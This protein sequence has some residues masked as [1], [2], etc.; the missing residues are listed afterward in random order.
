MKLKTK[1]GLAAIMGLGLIAVFTSTI[2]QV[3]LKNLA[4]PDFTYNATDL[5]YWYITEDWV[6]V[7]AACI[8]T[9]VPLYQVAL[10]KASIDSFRRGGTSKVNT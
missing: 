6:I 10:G 3:E 7:I 1:F 9:L 2:K 8:L 5:I 4:T